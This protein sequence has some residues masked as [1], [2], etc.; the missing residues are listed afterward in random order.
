MKRSRRLPLLLALAGALLL[1]PWAATGADPCPGTVGAARIVAVGD[2]HGSFSGLVEILTTTGLIDHDLHWTGGNATLVQVGDILDRGSDVRRV[3]DL[4]MRLQGE[5]RAAGGKVICLLGNHEAMNLFGIRSY[6]NKQAYAT[7]ADSKS[8]ARQKSAWKQQVRVWEKRVKRAG[9]IM[10]D[11][12]EET[13]TR[14]KEA[15]PPGSFE[16]GEALAPDG[17]YGKWLSSL[18]VAVVIGDTLFIHGGLSPA[19]KGLS[20]ADMNR[21]VAPELAE[22]VAARDALVKRKL[23]EPWAPIG[24]VALEADQEITRMSQELNDRQR[25]K[26][27]VAAY[28]RT[29]QAVRN[30]KSWILA[31][32]DGPLWTRDAAEWNEDERGAEMDALIEAA[33]ARRMVVGHTVQKTGSIQPRFGNRVFL[34]DTGMLKSEFDGRPSALEICGDIVTAIYT[35]ERQQLVGPDAAPPRA[36]PI[37]PAAGTAIPRPD[38]PP[39]PPEQGPAANP[40]SPHNGSRYRWL[41]V[42]GAPLPFQSDA[43]IERFLATAEVVSEENIPVGITKPIKVVLAKDGVRAHA[44]FKSIDQR[45]SYV[46]LKVLGRKTMLRSIHDYYLNDCAAYHLDRLLG[47]GRFPP[48]VPRTIGEQKGT[49]ELWLED[50]IMEKDRRD[51]HLRP[52]DPARL[53]S[54]RQI[55][56]IFD[57]IAGNT[58]TTNIGNALIDRYWDLWF[59]DCSRCFVTLSKPLT[60]QTVTNCERRLW[61]RLNEIS[62]DEMRTTLQPFLGRAEIDAVVK[63]KEAVVAHIAALVAKY[64]EAAV[65]FDLEPSQSEPAAW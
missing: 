5:S 64:G 43:A 15:Y 34:I 19:L 4:L 40:S 3:M 60:L 55:M 62:D 32:D 38:K 48:A 53:L 42:D 46:S 20:A 63:R 25:S 2:V 45:Q 27:K 36:P 28:I 35:D 16:Y 41:D 21:R 54:Q 52:P 18:P 12:P 24:V 30:W 37:Q 14:W 51:R 7:F 49:A 33:G 58:D 8:E 61:K 44:A 59:I 39:H 31:A 9:K 50:T 56:Y 10:V 57:N 6:V 65:L 22:F 23:A 26:R 13:K 17:R 11:I 1:A 47:I 29:L